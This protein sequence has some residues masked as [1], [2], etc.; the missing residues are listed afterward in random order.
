ML[1]L[2]RGRP[3][4]GHEPADH[5]DCDRYLV[6]DKSLRGFHIAVTRTIRSYRVQWDLP[7]RESI[8]RRQGMKARGETIVMTVGRVGE[9]SCRDAKREAARLLALIRSGTDPR[10]RSKID[11]STLKTAWENYRQALHNKRSSPQPDFVAETEDRI[12]MLEPKASN[13]MTDGEVLAKRDVAV[14]WCQQASNHARNH[15]GKPWTYAL[16]PHD[17]IAEN[18]TLEGLARR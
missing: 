12:L 18:M 16:I 14:R 3:P 6:W 15:S 7:A 17:T 2:A 5:L 1:P 4:L 9:I 13:Q 8:R 11:G 10:R